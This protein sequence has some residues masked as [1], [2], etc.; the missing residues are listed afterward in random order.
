MAGGGEGGDEGGRGS[1]G[2][3]GGDE[4]GELGGG[5]EGGEG[6]AG[7]AGG[8]EGGEGGGDGSPGQAQPEQS[9]RPPTV[10][11]VWDM[12]AQV[13]PSLCQNESQQTTPTNTPLTKLGTWEQLPGDPSPG[14]SPERARPVETAVR[15]VRGLGQ[16]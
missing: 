4:G 13:Q 2:G 1:E 8:V 6:G 5:G 10:V 16:G 9:Y 3:E 15:R 7:G 14:H 11:L 12:T